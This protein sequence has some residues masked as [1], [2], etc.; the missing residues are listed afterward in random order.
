M[1]FLIEKYKMDPGFAVMAFGLYPFSQ[2]LARLAGSRLTMRF[3]ASA[4]Q[5]AS[6]LLAIAGMPL[7]WLGGNPVVGLAGLF[8]TG[9]GVANLFPL[10]MSAAVGASGHLSDLASARISMI[11]GVALFSSPFALGWLA[12][13]VGLE[14]AYGLILG[15]LCAGLLIKLVVAWQTRLANLA[16]TP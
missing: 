10:T 7:L 12:D 5:T 11:V 15:L 4:L 9:V 1:S 8:V 14:S 6:F 2:V 3:S 13:R 16:A